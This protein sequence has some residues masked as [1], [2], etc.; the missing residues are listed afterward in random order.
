[1]LYKANHFPHSKLCNNKI[2]CKNK[3]V[4]ALCPETVSGTP[5]VI[6]PVDIFKMGFLGNGLEHF[7]FDGFCNRRLRYFMLI[8]THLL[9]LLTT[10]IT[11][12]TIYIR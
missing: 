4:L 10:Y 1:M 8:L 9:D 3:I 6:A 5:Q 7:I 2:N 12:Y 11:I